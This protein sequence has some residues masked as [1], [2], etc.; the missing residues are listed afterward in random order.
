M[1][2]VTSRLRRACTTLA[3]GLALAASALVSP[4]GAQAA[5]SAH[6]GH[7]PHPSQSASTPYY[8]DCSA[9]ANGDGSL[10]APY[11]SLAAAN[12]V[13]YGPGDRLYFKRG[14]TC[15]GQ[16]KPTGSGSAAAPVRVAPYGSGGARPVIEGGGTVYAAVHLL[17]VE[18]WEIR[19]LEITNK[20]ATDAE[21]N[22][23]LVE[24]ADH[25]TG[26]HY[27]LD[28]V[29]VHDVNGGD[30]KSSNGIQFRVSGT[31]T[32]TRFDDVLVENSEIYKVDREGLTT[33]SSWAC[34]AIY[35]CT[36]GPAWTASTRVVFRG[37]KI[38]DIGGDGMVVRVTRD[39]L[40]EHNEAYDIW[41]RSAGNNAGLWTIN[42]DGTVFQYNEV[43]HVRRKA[44]MN[45]GMA[46]DADFGTRGALFQYN[47]S[48]DNEGGFLLLCGACGGGADTAGTVARYNLSVN[49]GSRILY[50]VGD[51]AAQILDN[52]F[53]MGAG[54]TTSVVESSG[55][56]STTLWSNNIVYNLGTGGY[57]GKPAEH[58]WRNNVMYGNH[59]AS[60][61][62][63]PG[64][65]TADPLLADPGS[66]DPAGYALKAGSPARGA[67]QV[68]TGS[69]GKDYF[70]APAPVACRPDIG[71]HQA[72]AFDDAACSGGTNLV[73]DPGFETGVSPWV[74][75]GA[76]AA[77][78]A[79]P[80]G[81]GSS[82]RVSGTP[83]TAEQKITVAPNTTY[84]LSGWGRVDA[85]D[86]Q[87]AVGVKNFGGSETRIP[88][89]SAFGWRTGSITFTTGATNTSATLYCYTR[90][91]KGSGWCDD[92]RIVKQ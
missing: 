29:Y 51:A 9:A 5:G 61:P 49:D 63:D 76:V 65:V 71:A 32:P 50:A 11:N 70:G 17:N 19:G 6:P 83:S 89:F 21:R 56:A 42:S 77:D 45:D 43:H 69:G 30:T 91:G 16:L 26:T 23:I 68:T 73:A 10:A 82:L 60:E 57:G 1:A 15:R 2:P 59:P 67:G 64:K 52:T 53:Y 54:S 27:V 78:T 31:V 7:P 58:T 48:H 13:T 74:P 41:M 24:L 87:L 62:A 85:Y 75:S 79:N 90:T 25:G 14:A 18:Q 12:A 84:T 36:S 40:A 66:A 4:P 34:R 28:D 47:Y 46:F 37:N 92:L 81:G 33:Q 72:S 3:A 20:G 39:A 44:G 88:A 8:V 86:T 38:H 22:G 80:H 55:G 35:G